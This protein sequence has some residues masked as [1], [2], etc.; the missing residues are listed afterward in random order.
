M[1]IE[2]FDQVYRS[3]IYIGRSEDYQLENI[4]YENRKI[5]CKIE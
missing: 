2:L 4:R 5:H 1:L 3:V